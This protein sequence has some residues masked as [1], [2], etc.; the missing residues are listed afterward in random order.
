MSQRTNTYE[1]RL[2]IRVQA[3]SED[4]ARAIATACKN[5]L[6]DVTAGVFGAAGQRV[7]V[8]EIKKLDDE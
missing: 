3:C 1:I 7:R 4:H 5:R 2:A 8:S 6:V